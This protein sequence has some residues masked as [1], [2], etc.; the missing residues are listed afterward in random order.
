M[1]QIVGKVTTEIIEF[2]G[3][4]QVDNSDAFPVSTYRQLVEHVAN[5]TFLGERPFAIFQ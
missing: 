5:G 3:D 4:K 2:I 1:R